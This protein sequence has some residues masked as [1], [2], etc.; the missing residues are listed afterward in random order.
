MR[1][2]TETTDQ[3]NAK[4]DISIH[5]P[6]AGRDHKLTCPSNDKLISIHAPR[7]GRDFVSMIKIQLLMVFQSTR[8]VRGA[9]TIIPNQSAFIHISI[10]APRAGRDCSRW[11]LVSI[12][13]LFQ[14]TRPVRGATNH[15]P[16]CR[17]C[18]SVFQST[19]PVRGATCIVSD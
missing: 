8:P 19:R 12:S 16:G 15:F 1:G 5:A 10:H 6:R 17:V 14:S 9:T 2:A 3:A 11:L 7:A 4:A 13:Y 18:C